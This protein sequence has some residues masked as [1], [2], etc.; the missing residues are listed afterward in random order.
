[1]FS[2]HSQIPPCADKMKDFGRNFKGSAVL[3]C[4]ENSYFL[5]KVTRPTLVCIYPNR[6]P[7]S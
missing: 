4:T 1:M 5:S 7:E 2:A 3:E 6:M